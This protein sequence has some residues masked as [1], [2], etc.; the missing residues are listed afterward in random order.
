MVGMAQLVS[1]PDCG[2]GG[3]GF[4]SQYPPLQG[5][6]QAVRHRTLTPASAGSN[7]ASPATG[8]LLFPVL[9]TAQGLAARRPRIPFR[10]GPLAQAVEHLTFNQVVSGSSPEWLSVIKPL[11]RTGFKGFVLSLDF[12]WLIFRR[13]RTIIVNAADMVEL[14][15]TPD[16]GSG[17]QACRFKSCCPHKKVRYRSDTSLFYAVTGA[18]GFEPTTC[19]FGDRYSTS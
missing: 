3:P 1:A 18:V 5:Y 16:L 19:G 15:D 12:S 4:E 17:A 11:K 6:R 14:V 7:P 13:G 10:Y 2:S 8:L 9:R